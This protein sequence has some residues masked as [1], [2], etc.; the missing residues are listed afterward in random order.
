MPAG[1]LV[2]TLEK[3]A[4]A[5]WSMLWTRGE[6]LMW[7]PE[8]IG[9]RS[10]EEVLGEVRMGMRIRTS[11]GGEGGIWASGRKVL[12]SRRLVLKRRRF[13]EDYRG[14]RSCSQSA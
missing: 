12:R 8:V 6:G 5:E 3:M 13:K 2:V 4:I 11:R 10:G 14:R 9:G 7:S 1:S